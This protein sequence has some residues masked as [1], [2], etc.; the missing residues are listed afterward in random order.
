VRQDLKLGFNKPWLIRSDGE[1][2]NGDLRLK[3][4]RQTGHYRD[5]GDPVR[6]M[7]ERRALVSI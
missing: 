3:A 6:R 7:D 2:I 4:A 5:S 1:V